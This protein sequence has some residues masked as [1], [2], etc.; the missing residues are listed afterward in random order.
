MAQLKPAELFIMR[1]IICEV[2]SRTSGT[3]FGDFQLLVGLELVVVVR[4]PY[5]QQINDWQQG[6][7]HVNFLI[8][9]RLFDIQL[10]V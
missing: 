4:H 7:V 8:H 5:S 9:T 2:V 6:N 3:T 10:L 1:Y